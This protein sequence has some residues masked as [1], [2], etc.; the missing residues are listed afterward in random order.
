LNFHFDHV[1]CRDTVLPMKSR[2]KRLLY[3]LVLLGAAVIAL[4]GAARCS[5]V[6]RTRAYFALQR[7]WLAHW[8]LPRGKWLPAR[9][10]PAFEPLVPVRM[11]VEPGVNMLLDPEDLI[12]NEIL[13]TGQWEADSWAIIKE[14]LPVGG[15]FVDL[16]AH[17]GYYSLKAARAVGPKGQVIAIEPNPETVRQLRDN[18][19]ASGAKV[20]AVEP[21][22][23]SDSEAELELFAAPRANTGQT[24]LSR[25]NAQQS[26]AV[27]AVYRVRARPLDAIIQ[28]AGVSR[29]DVVKIDVEGAELLVLKGAK[30]TLARYSPVL[31]V[32][33]MDNQLQ[34]MG[35]SAAELKEFLRSQ[36]YTPSHSLDLNIEFAK[37]IRIQPAPLRVP[38]P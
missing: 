1:R 32:E 28:E 15:T 21:V 2:R 33:V 9:V 17:I 34:A 18:I 30:Q 37:G 13:N 5:P 14:H 3:A 36:G 25:A 12:S 20:I 35:T 10:R 26:G 27:H 29:V 22:A 6:G 31:F 24:S 7:G 11:E 38:A 19:Q 16:G 4:W 23:C 8:P